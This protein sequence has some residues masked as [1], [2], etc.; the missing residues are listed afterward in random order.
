MS[1]ELKSQSCPQEAPSRDA[2]RAALRE[3]FGFESFHPGQ[4]EI[5]EKVLSGR[6]VLAIFPSGYGKSLL[7]QLPASLLPGMTLVFSP[8]IALMR[9]QQVAL[10]RRYRLPSASLTSD[11]Q[12]A[13]PR[14]FYGA[15]KGVGE[16]RYKVVFI[17]PERLD[18]E[19]VM[20]TI[21]SQP[22]SLV[23]IDEAHCVSIWGHDFRPHYRRILR[24]V[25]DVQ[26]PAVLALT[27]TAPPP[28]EADILRQIPG[29]AEVFR[30]SPQRDSLHLHV[31]DVDGEPEKLSCL[32]R[33]IPRLEGSGVVYCGTQEEC[34]KVAEFLNLCGIGSTFYHAGLGK[35]RA[36]IERDFLANRWKAVAA[37][38]AL[39]M[40][41]DKRD[42]RFVIHYRFPGSPE[43][44]YQEI[45]RAGRDGR[46]AKCI[47]LF[48]PGD[49]ALQEFF[50]SKNHPEPDDYAVVFGCLD[51]TEPQTADAI[52]GDTGL[53]RSLVE[54]VLDNLVEAGLA[55][56]VAGAADAP[57]FCLA[58]GR[59]SYA[60]IEPFLAARRKRV[61]ALDAM[62]DYGETGECLMAYLCRYL[63]GG[64]T[65]SCGQCTHCR[66]FAEKYDRYRE[67][68][69]QVEEFLASRYP[70]LNSC[71]DHEGGFA[72]DFHGGTEVGEAVSDAKYRGEETVPE[73]LVKKAAA[74]IA[75]KYRDSGA[76][77]IDALTFIPPTSDRSL[78]EDF[79]RRLAGRLHV[80]CTA[81]LTR[82]RPTD[83]QKDMRTRREKRQNIR[84]AFAV[85]E[86]A[87]SPGRSLLLVDDIY[88]SGW[89]LREAARVIRRV[90]PECRIRVFTLTRT[91]HSDDF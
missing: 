7:Y 42:L 15:L 5:I 51:R 76:L 87:E 79:A 62:V 23:V 69:A 30:L 16:G 33:I 82:G 74:C 2:I 52:G 86:G 40:G 71:G 21:R 10:S 13:D 43:L 70:R 3:R 48:D 4:E 8:L 61:E 65:Q 44:Y 78:V 57:G 81:L 27:A 22:I 80:P 49:L 28:V 77:A 19:R 91:H 41:I 9:D 60:A 29:S 83:L 55:R 32:A 47:L 45:G 54:V 26:P 24:F 46:P 38:C 6:N 59:P 35:Q 85:V 64:E 67:P 39:G 37:T 50:L 1:G 58:R 88:D 34:E 18:N 20:E 73:W 53:T 11:L 84:D 66:D 12:S 17:A 14:K 68:M 56:R 72:L 31:I 25:A 90:F 75:K 63:G 36:A 89:T